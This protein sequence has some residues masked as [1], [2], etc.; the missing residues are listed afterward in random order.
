QYHDGKPV[1]GAWVKI[2][3]DKEGRVFNVLNSLVPDTIVA[4]SKK[5]AAAKKG[6]V[7]QTLSEGQVKQLA[8]QAAGPSKDPPAVLE[9]ELVSYPHNGVIIPAW[10]VIVQTKRPAAEWRMYLDAS[11]GAVLEKRDQLLRVNG[12][13]RVFDPNPVVALNDTTLKDNS[14]IPEAAYAQVT[15]LDLK[16]G[17]QLD[18]PFVSTSDTP[19]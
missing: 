5:A 11:T 3:I 6:L 10:K 8:L 14:K 9:Q 13:G 15:L 17:G 4:K 19:Q 1:T 7:A 16:A 2:D 18:G 12:T